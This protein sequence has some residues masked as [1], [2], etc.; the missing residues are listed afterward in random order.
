LWFV[1]Q[2]E[3]VGDVI[4]QTEQVVGGWLRR[5]EQAGVWRCAA[6]HRESQHNTAGNPIWFILAQRCF[7]AATRHS[8]EFVVAKQKTTSGSGSRC[9]GRKS[10]F[11]SLAENWSCG[12]HKSGCISGCNG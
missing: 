11:S 7:V 4:A 8:A 5:P 10:N 2:T 6:L 3:K 1:A 9:G 12:V